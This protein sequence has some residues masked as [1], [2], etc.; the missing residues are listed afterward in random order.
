VHRAGDHV[1]FA[2]TIAI[3]RLREGVRRLAAWLPGLRRR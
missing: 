3:D 1:R 2:Y